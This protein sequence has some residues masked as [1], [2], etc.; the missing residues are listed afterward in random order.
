[1]S[2]TL[3]VAGALLDRV[4]LRA[5]GLEDLLARLGVPGGSLRERRHRRKQISESE[6][7]EKRRPTAT[8]SPP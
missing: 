2:L 5:L 4:A 8:S 7:T 3:L 1:M 6:P